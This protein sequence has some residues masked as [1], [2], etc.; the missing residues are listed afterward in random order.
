MADYSKFVALAQRLI[1]KRGRAVTMRELSN[2]SSDASK[3]WKGTGAPTVKVEVPTTAVFLD[4]KGS[5]IKSIVKDDDML[6][7]VTDVALVAPNVVDLRN[8]TQLVDG[9]AMK[10]EWVQVLQPG[11]TVCLYVFGVTR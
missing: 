10:I 8:M 1:A 2:A 3:P 6:K 11:D 7:R 4:P 9:K 5:D